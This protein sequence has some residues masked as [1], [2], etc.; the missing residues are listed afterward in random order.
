MYGFINN[1]VHGVSAGLDIV[2]TTGEADNA[3][4]ITS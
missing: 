3:S 2:S 4:V 1:F